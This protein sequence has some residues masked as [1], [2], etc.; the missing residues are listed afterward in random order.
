MFL[1]FEKWNFKSSFCE[2]SDEFSVYITQ[3][4]H[5]GFHKVLLFKCWVITYKKIIT[6]LYHADNSWTRFIAFR[7]SMC[8]H[9]AVLL[10]QRTFLWLLAKGCFI[11]VAI[12]TAQANSVSTLKSAMLSESLRCVVR[13]E[14]ENKEEHFS[15]RRMQQTKP[16]KIPMWS[17]TLFIFCSWVGSEMFTWTT[18]FC[19]LVFQLALPVQTFG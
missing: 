16:S 5:R 15:C 8:E 13:K 12:L 11:A 17:D 3:R 10:I 14:N 6:H 7:L 1:C 18:I 4:W 2:G 9:L 19:F